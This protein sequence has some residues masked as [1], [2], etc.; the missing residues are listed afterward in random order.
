MIFSSTKFCW[1]LNNADLFGFLN[2]RLICF[3]WLCSCHVFS[4]SYVN[5]IQMTTWPKKMSN[6][7]K[8]RQNSKIKLTPHYSTNNKQTIFTIHS[9]S[10][11]TVYEEA[12]V[13]R[14]KKSKGITLKG[15]NFLWCFTKVIN[16]IRYFPTRALIA[17]VRPHTTSPIILLLTE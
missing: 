1:K 5:T 13:T 11:S 10:P 15:L 16:K 7:N 4:R 3:H 17:N 12:G 2:S 14:K 8:T 6:E 9:F